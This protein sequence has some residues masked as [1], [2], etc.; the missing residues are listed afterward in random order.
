MMAKICKTFLKMDICGVFGWR[1]LIKSKAPISLLA[2]EPCP[3]EKAQF[4]SEAQSTFPKIN[5]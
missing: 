2:K 5:R 3:S 1:F 4:G